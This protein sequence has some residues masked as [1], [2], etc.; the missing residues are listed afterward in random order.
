MTLPLTVLKQALPFMLAVG[1]WLTPVPAR[2]IR[3]FFRS[4]TVL[5]TNGLSD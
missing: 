1:I 2:S 5:I 3:S 4:C